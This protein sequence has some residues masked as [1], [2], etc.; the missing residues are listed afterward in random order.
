LE[1]PISSNNNNNDKNNDN[2]GIPIVGNPSS[3]GSQ[4]YSGSN[5]SS[6]GRTGTIIGR[7]FDDIKKEV[8]T[9]LS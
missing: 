6:D 8:S 9:F 4:I 5:N 3:N 2:N 7:N 1:D